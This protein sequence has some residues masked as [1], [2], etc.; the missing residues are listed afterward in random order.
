MSDTHTAGFGSDGSIL[1]HNVRFPDWGRLFSVNLSA[2]NYCAQVLALG[3]THTVI[4]QLCGL[5]CPIPTLEDHFERR[6]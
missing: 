2:V 3:G 1:N 6:R 5:V 4:A